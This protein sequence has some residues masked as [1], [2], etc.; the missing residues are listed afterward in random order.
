L[1]LARSFELGERLDDFVRAMPGP[2]AERPFDPRST[3]VFAKGKESGLADISDR[4]HG[5]EAERWLASIVESSDDT[6]ISNDLQGIIRSWNTGAQRLFGY[7]AE[8][9]VGKSI[10]ILI[11]SD[12]QDDEP[13]ILER[14]RCGERI[15]H[16][17][18][19]R[20]RK[21]GSLVDISLTVSPVKDARGEVIGASKI[22]RDITERK[23][24][25]NCNS[26]LPTK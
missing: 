26:F 22:A 14:L 23:E 4:K 19:V 18:T 13:S 21:D 15:E 7:F 17:E 6:I 16:Y 20:L 11:P 2:M 1:L 10:T 9:V 8:E 5:D 12:R 25:A 3:G 24:H